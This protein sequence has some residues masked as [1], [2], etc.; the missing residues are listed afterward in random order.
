MQIR[1]FSLFFFYFRSAQL[2]YA[3]AFDE[4]RSRFVTVGRIDQMRCTFGQTRSAIDQMRTRLANRARDLPNARAFGPNAQC[5]WSILPTVTKCERNSANVRAFG[6]LRWSGVKKKTENAYLHITIATKT[7]QSLMCKI[8][9]Q[10]F[11][12]EDLKVT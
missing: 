8:L 11:N 5:I 6:Q 4:F 2:A 12:T 10:N 3:R 7:A 9:N 1:V